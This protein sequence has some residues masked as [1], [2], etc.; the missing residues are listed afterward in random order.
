MTTTGAG[1][2]P[3]DLSWLLT[4]LEVV[5]ALVLCAGVW[6]IYHPAALILAG[7]LGVFACERR[8]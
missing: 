3:R 7:V 2:K 4:L 6:Q 1:R 8:Q 5:F